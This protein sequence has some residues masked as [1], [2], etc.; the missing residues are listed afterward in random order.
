MINE[1]EIGDDGVKFRCF[2]CKSLFRIM[3]KNRAIKGRHGT[4]V[5][6]RSG[7][8]VKFV[9]AHE[10]PAFCEA[11]KRV[12]ANE[13][14]IVYDSNDGGEALAIIERVKPDAVL[15]DVALPTMYGFELCEA[16]RKNPELAKTKIILLAAIYDKRRYRRDPASMYGA[17]EVIEKHRIPDELIPLVHLLVHPVPAEDVS[18]VALTAV[19]EQSVE[20]EQER[21]AATASPTATA[22]TSPALAATDA[23]DTPPVAEPA[24][25]ADSDLFVAGG[26]FDESPGSRALRAAAPKHEELPVVEVTVEAEPLPDAIAASFVDEITVE[27]G[28]VVASSPAVTLPEGSDV[29]ADHVKARRLARIIISD[30]ALYN[31]EKVRQ[32]VMDGTLLTILADEISEGEA[33]Y[34]QRVAAEIRNGTDYLKEALHDL[35]A[36]KKRE[37]LG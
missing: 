8:V 37:Y 24:V 7:T 31:P 19:A 4:S 9:I 28:P 35:I 18:A 27:E 32:G 33:L 26:L 12:V 20:R 16:I 11:V 6:D 22:W 10:S 29:S 13:P 34:C 30:V 17:D 36:K 25:M 2:R 3:R 21:L 1:A 15:L 14:F 23:G 5:G